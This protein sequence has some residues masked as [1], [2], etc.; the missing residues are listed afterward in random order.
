MASPIKLLSYACCLVIFLNILN[1]V[2]AGRDFYKILGL[3]RDATDREIKKAYR[4]LAMK[5]H[6]DKNPDDP[7]AAEK[8]QDL[9]AAYEVLSDPDKR[10]TYDQH[11]EE[12]VKKMGGF[13]DSGGFDPFSSFFGGF[14]FSFGSQNE[15]NR[16]S[17]T[18]KGAEVVMDLEVTLEEL[19]TGEFVE[20]MRAKPVAKTVPG[21]RKCNCRM[22]MK[23]TQLGP[24]R[25][26]MMQEEVCDD[27]PQINFVTEEKLLE[28]EIEPGMIDGQEYP[29]LAEGEP[30]VDGDPG[31]L[32]FKI[33]VLKHD[34]FER[35]GDDLYT[36]VTLSLVDALN[37]FDLDIQHLDGHK[38]HIHREKITWPGAKIKKAN[39]G[40]P[41]YSDNLQ[42]G[43]L[44]ITF[45]VNFPKGELTNEEKQGRFSSFFL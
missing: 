34:R 22:E 19:Y 38:V 30:H 12:G 41:N 44:Y 2:L 29:F 36:N 17:E 5:W 45:D 28:V 37:G 7:S 39:E 10:R 3:S 16:H 32:K 24:G 8:F 35:R 1:Q 31:D 14:G 11:G 33:S 9:G 40:M 6:P 21:T 23:T 42:K 20:V 4:K 15:G 26:Q 27:C 25:F 18:P 13:E 43:F